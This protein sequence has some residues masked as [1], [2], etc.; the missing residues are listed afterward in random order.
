M[1]K[2]LPVIK[3]EKMNEVNLFRFQTPFEYFFLKSLTLKNESSICHLEPLFLTSVSSTG[4]PAPTC[5]SSASGGAW[6]GINS[7]S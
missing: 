1:S 7:G 2:I 3:K 5:P 6:S 4:V